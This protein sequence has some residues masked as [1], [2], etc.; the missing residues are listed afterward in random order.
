MIVD[1]L[2]L[3]MMCDDLSI[4]DD[5]SNEMWRIKLDQH[6]WTPRMD[7]DLLLKISKN[8]SLSS[9]GSNIQQLH[10]E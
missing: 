9:K 1:Y 10:V 3:F 8:D 4:Y 5:L 6:G 7:N 2:Y